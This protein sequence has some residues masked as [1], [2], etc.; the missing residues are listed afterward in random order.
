M[1]QNDIFYTT[2]AVD[3]LIEFRVEADGIVLMSYLFFLFF[4]HLDSCVAYFGR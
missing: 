4:F 2:S 3:A 1:Y